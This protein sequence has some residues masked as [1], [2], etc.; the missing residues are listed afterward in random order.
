MATSRSTPAP[1]ARTRRKPAESTRERI[2]AAAADEF[3]S[4]GLAGARVDSIAAAADCNKAMLYYFF[5][6]KDDLY[7]EVLEEFYAH[8]REHERNLHLG[9]LLPLEAIK[10]LVEFKFDYYNRH[11]ILIKLL[12]TENLNEAHYL[13]QS[14]RLRSMQSPLLETLTGLLKAGAEEG[15]MRADV[16]PVQLYISIAALAYFYFANASTLSTAFGRDLMASP[17]KLMR[18]QHAVEVILGYLKLH[19]PAA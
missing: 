6:S 18:R 4:K 12:S 17:A 7:L 3:A 15:S 10:R 2:L 14:T 9:H 8:M 16:D 13:K 1:T 5:A 11:P 19:P